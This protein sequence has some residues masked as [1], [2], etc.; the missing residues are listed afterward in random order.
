MLKVVK[1][2]RLEKVGWDYKANWPQVSASMYVST[3]GDHGKYVHESLGSNVSQRDIIDLCNSL[4]C[5]GGVGRSKIGE[6]E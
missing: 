4:P 3:L 2:G 6:I 5:L 1:A